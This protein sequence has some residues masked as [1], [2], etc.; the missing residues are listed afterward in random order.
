VLEIG[1]TSLDAA[2]DD[3]RNSDI[4]LRVFPHLVHV[5]GG[6][7]HRE[8]RGADA[9]AERQAEDCHDAEATVLRQQARGKA[10]VAHQMLPPQAATRLVESLLAAAPVRQFAP[11]RLLR[12][13]AA[14]PIRL[15]LIGLKLQ[16]RLNLRLKIR[17]VSLAP[18]DYT[19]GPSTRAIAAASFLHW[20]VSCAS[21]FRPALVSL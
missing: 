5:H 6:G 16:V 20:L 19:S 9:D 14:H 21:C 8:D 4:R 13:V 17:L 3:P 18:H 12:F 2:P 10:K 1:K 15:K 7:D 11:R